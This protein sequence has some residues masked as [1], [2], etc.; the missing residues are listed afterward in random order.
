VAKL[1]DQCEVSDGRLAMFD[2]ESV[3][4]IVAALPDGPLVT[5]LVATAC[6]CTTACVNRWI[7]RGTRLPDGSRV[8]LSA[9][10]AGRWYTRRESLGEFLVA[11]GE[12][13]LAAAV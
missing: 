10:W 3:E 1:F 6:R 4:E 13:R 9:W 8:K 7:L 12:G 2:C 11:V 5:K